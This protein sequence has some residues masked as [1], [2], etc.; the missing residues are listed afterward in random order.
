MADVPVNGVYSGQGVNESNFAII[1]V[2]LET[3]LSTSDTVTLTLPANVPDDLVPISMACYDNAAPRASETADL[4]VTSHNISTG[5]TILT[6][7]A[8]VADSSTIVM[9][10]APCT[11]GT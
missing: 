11:L 7:S 5:V 1:E 8:A 4:A 9:L 10:Y 2:E 6:A 3:A